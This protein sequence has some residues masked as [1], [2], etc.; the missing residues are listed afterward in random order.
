MYALTD[1]E[2][3]DRQIAEAMRRTARLRGEIANGELE[4]R[5]VT[6]AVSLL[7]AF[8]VALKSL[9]QHRQHILIDLGAGRS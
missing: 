8:V 4:G 7:D 1:L 3:A 6:C 9:V 2:L 5:D